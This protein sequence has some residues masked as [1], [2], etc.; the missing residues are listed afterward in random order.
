MRRP[1]APATRFARVAASLVLSSIVVALLAAAGPAQAR[2][3]FGMGDQHAATFLDPTLRGLGLQTA[4]LA[5]PWDW[6]REPAQVAA[7]DAWMATVRAA[8]LRP[9][10][11]MNRNWRRGGQRLLPP[12]AAYRTSFRALRTRYPDVR[13][14]AAWNEANHKTQ[15]LYRNPKAAARY[16]NAMK[17]LCRGCSVVAADVLDDP[18]MARWIATFKRYAHHPRLWGLHNYRDANRGTGATRTFLRITRGSVWLTE[19]GGIHRLSAIRRG[20]TASRERQ[21]LARQAAAVR[22]VFAIARS[23]RRIRRVYFYQWKR[24]RGAL[25]DSAF[26]NADGS[27]RPAFRALAAGLRG[28][29]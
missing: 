10:I 9:M 20:S 8:G 15:P 2:P 14:F 6:Y 23:S 27:R 22:R 1:L 18:G 12:M 19:T 11:A 29:R 17:A 28:V 16:F 13:D 5:V 4:R 24:E 25:W 3:L 26:L 21:A 7:T